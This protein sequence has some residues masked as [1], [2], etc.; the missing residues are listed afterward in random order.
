MHAPFDAPAA[1]LKQSIRAFLTEAIDPLVPDAERN[2]ELSPKLLHALADRGFWGATVPLHHGGLGWDSV[3]IGVLCE[4]L[5]RCSASVLSA[6]TVHAMVCDTLERFGSQRLR[7]EWLPALARGKIQAA[8]ALSEPDAGSDSSRIK[9]EATTL[10]SGFALN[11]TKRWVSMGQVAGLFLVFARQGGA[12]GCYLVSGASPGLARTPIRGMSGMRAA[13]LAELEFT[14]CLVGT[15]NAIGPAG[16]ALGMVAGVALTLGRLCIAA[17]S[18]GIIQGCLDE[19]SRHVRA[20]EQ[21]QKPL[22]EHQLVQGMLADMASALRAS[23]LLWH[24]AAKLREAGDERVAVE[25][26]VA[27]Y[28]ASREA[29]EAARHAVQAH[30]AWGCTEDTPVARYYRDAK[31]MEII[32]GTNEVAKLV[33]ARHA[34]L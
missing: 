6:F 13:M 19:S 4:E 27:K 10:A 2:Q 8:F 16:L 20:R 28:F 11:G 5:G 34:H 14:D 29:Q 7:D 33:I 15:E 22:N 3:S 9:C 25:M 1:A 18:T 26:M 21:F 23:R 30:G 31:I 17:G 12:S 32:E 24:E